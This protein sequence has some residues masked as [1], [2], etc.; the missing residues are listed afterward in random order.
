MGL[1]LA[2]VEKITDG[3]TTALHVCDLEEA[4]VPLP[5]PHVL[6]ALAGAYV[7]SYE[8]LMEKAGHLNRRRDL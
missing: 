7:I 8:E 2:D 5:A 4:K 6:Y 1:T 3:A